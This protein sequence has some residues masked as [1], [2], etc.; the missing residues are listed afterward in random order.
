MCIHWTFS[1]RIRN[2]F[3]HFVFFLLFCHWNPSFPQFHT[4]FSA[5]VVSNAIK[6]MQ[7][8]ITYSENY[9]NTFYVH[10]LCL[11][12]ALILFC[13]L[14]LFIAYFLLFFTLFRPFSPCLS[15]TF[16]LFASNAIRLLCI[17]WF[18]KLHFFN[19]VNVL[20][21]F[22]SQSLFHAFIRYIYQSLRLLV[23]FLFLKLI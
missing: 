21:S 15:A 5:K 17:E 20:P 7:W 14:A 12:C 11:F 4:I 8:V 10:E 19:T 2:W 3:F 1:L 6:W 9:H 23:L 18:A 16:I 22:A 13:A